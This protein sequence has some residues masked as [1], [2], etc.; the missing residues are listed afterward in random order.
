MRKILKSGIS[1]DE[2]QYY[3]LLEWKDNNGDKFNQF[4]RAN[5]LNNNPSNYSINNISMVFYIRLLIFAGFKPK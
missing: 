3:E 2:K 1:V 4:L 5:A